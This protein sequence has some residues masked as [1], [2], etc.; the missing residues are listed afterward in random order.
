[1]RA[2]CRIIFH[3]VFVGPPYYANGP[4][5]IRGRCETHQMDIPEPYAT[6]GLMC[7]VGRV[8]KAVDDGLAKIEVALSYPTVTGAKESPVE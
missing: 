7:P 6:V 8:E 2:E 5:T 3:P 1:M 4:T